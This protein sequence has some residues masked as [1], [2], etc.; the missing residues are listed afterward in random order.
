MNVVALVRKSNSCKLHHY[1]PRKKKYR[2]A[3]TK[4]YLLGD[5][6][7]QH[8]CLSL[9]HF[10]LVTSL[11]LPVHFLL[12]FWH[13]AISY[14]LTRPIW[15]CS[16]PKGGMRGYIPHKRVEILCFILF[17]ETKRTRQ[18]NQNGNSR[19]LCFALLTVVFQGTSL[20]SLEYLRNSLL[21]YKY[22]HLGT[23]S[24]LPW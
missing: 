12:D 5:V 24:S 20:H 6:V 3:R 1:S 23:I 19:P 17:T 16:T 10:T 22:I 13:F 9:Q 11:K 4:S 15:T 7:L 21:F 2:Q 14:C 8:V 18:K